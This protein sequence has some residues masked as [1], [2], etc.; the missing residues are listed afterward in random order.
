MAETAP[1]SLKDKTVEGA[2]ETLD[3]TRHELATTA[4]KR[5][6]PVEQERANVEAAERNAEQQVEAA[7]PV[8]AEVTK[9]NLAAEEPAAAPAP[10]T[11]D[12]P[13]MQQAVR[14]Y[15]GQVRK[16]LSTSDKVFSEFVH[17]PTIN[18]ISE[19]TGKTLI[20][21]SGI[22]MG[23]L[24]TLVGSAWYYYATNHTGYHYNFVFAFVLFAGG[25]ILGV[26]IEL[27]FKLLAKGR[28]A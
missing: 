4:E 11:L 9:Q 28:K 10:N 24:C 12:R 14:T 1:E 13:Q 22:L 16:H 20:R 7:Q 23:G 6:E 19:A 25:F 21:P 27:L 3:E 15:L 8:E 5:A 2:Q 17:N 26:V 18:A